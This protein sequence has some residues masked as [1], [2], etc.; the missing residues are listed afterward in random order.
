MDIS[1]ITVED[2]YQRTKLPCIAERNLTPEVSEAM[3]QPFRQ[4][5]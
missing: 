3:K 4:N 2:V 5:K 1:G